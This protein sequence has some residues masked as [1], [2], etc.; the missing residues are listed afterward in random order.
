MLAWPNGSFAPNPMGQPPGVSRAE[1]AV[2]PGS[3]LLD[4]LTDRGP[5]VISRSGLRKTPKETAASGADFQTTG[6]VPAR[7]G[8]HG[9]TQSTQSGG[10][11][12]AAT[13]ATAEER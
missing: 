5:S 12:A 10:E 7:T 6:A 4:E 9:T 13:Q 11:E 3:M 1:I 2:Y 8:W